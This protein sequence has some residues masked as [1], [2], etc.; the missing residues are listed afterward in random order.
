MEGKQEDRASPLDFPSAALAEQ[1][2]RR[3]AQERFEQNISPPTIPRSTNE[4]DT[5][6]IF[7]GWQ[8]SGSIFSST[9]SATSEAFIGAAGGGISA[10]TGGVG[11]VNAPS[12]NSFRPRPATNLRYGGRT[13]AF[14]SS[15]LRQS[16]FH[17]QIQAYQQRSPQ[18]RG[19][20]RSS[21]S[22]SS[23]LSTLNTRIE[24]NAPL[25]WFSEP[26]QREQHQD[27]A[28]RQFVASGSFPAPLPPGGQFFTPL[29]AAVSSDHLNLSTAGS[30]NSLDR[31]ELRQ[32]SASVPL[33]LP[34][35]SSAQSY[36]PHSSGAGIQTMGSIDESVSSSGDFASLANTRSP[37]RARGR[38]SRNSSRS[39]VGE[40]STQ[41]RSVSSGRSSVSS[42]NN[43]TINY[44]SPVCY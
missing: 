38:A 5:N 35:S 40:T 11:N 15:R 6:R 36:R 29:P 13:S 7:H 16:P 43:N 18:G 19:Q 41:D 14:S 32:M 22:I 25:S 9:N 33:C 42:P 20:S 12:L 23:D 17:G 2:R 44:F 27:F 3:L 28:P 1:R 8:N 4:I 37:Y 39:S 31:E 21:N 26:N 30:S 10:S 24:D 34:V